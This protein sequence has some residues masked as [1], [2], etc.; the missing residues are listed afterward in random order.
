MCPQ[1]GAAG[2][3]DQMG[4][5]QTS[6][7]AGGR[8][9]GTGRTHHRLGPTK[10]DEAARSQP[11]C[12]TPG[13]TGYPPGGLIEVKGDAHRD[14]PVPQ[15]PTNQIRFSIIEKLVRDLRQHA[16]C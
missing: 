3:H 6:G 2:A 16:H 14:N 8:S 15:E 11:L 5:A 7:G 9:A 13:A 4:S 12:P 1:S 10:I